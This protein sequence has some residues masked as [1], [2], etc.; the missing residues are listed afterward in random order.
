[1]CVSVCVVDWAMLCV[2]QGTVYQA[3]EQW[4]VD[5]CTGCTCVSGEVH[6]HSER[7][8]PLS[9]NMVSTYRQVKPRYSRGVVADQQP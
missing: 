9:C 2:H 3:H 1:M 8:P 5:E 7:C 4:Q 6:C